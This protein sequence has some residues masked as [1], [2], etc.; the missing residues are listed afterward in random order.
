MGI[1]R[2][3]LN[4]VFD[5]FYTTKEKGTGLGLSVSYN[6]IKKM[7]GTIN[8]ESEVGKGTLFTVAIPASNEHV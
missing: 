8:V 5:P 4:R 6:I 3:E 2:E 7:G 1:P